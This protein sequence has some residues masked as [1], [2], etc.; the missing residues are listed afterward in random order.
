MYSR[1]VAFSSVASGLGNT[2]QT[3]YGWSN[4]TLERVIEQRVADGLPGIAIQ[5]GAVGDVGIVLE[6]LGDNSTVV[7]GTL[8]QRIPSCLQALDTF[9]SWQHPI[10][11]S[12]VRAETK[13]KRAVGPG[14]IAQAIAQVLGVTDASQL[15]PDATLGDLGL[16]SLM[17]AE[18]KQVVEHHY[19]IVLSMKDTRN[20]RGLNLGWASLVC[21][22]YIFQQLPSLAWHSL[23]SATIRGYTV[24]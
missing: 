17:G 5:W 3:N 11:S 24:L 2:G 23:F 6:N 8:P 10:V 9:M 22:P 13:V 19:E 21:L 16:D 20:V 15:D 4:C 7:G 18:I 14:E 1:F 12:Y